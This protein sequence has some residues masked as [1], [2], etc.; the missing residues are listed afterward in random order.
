MA[1]FIMVPCMA[2]IHAAE[3]DTATVSSRTRYRQAS[4]AHYA[5]YF[6]VSAG[7]STGMGLSYRRWIGTKDA[8]QI[9][10]GPYYNNDSERAYTYV[11]SGLTYYRSFVKGNYMRFLGYAAASY[12]YDDSW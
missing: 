1:V 9:T 6:G 5:N 11:S 10:V 4:G 7:W 12:E 2:A 8:L 3:P